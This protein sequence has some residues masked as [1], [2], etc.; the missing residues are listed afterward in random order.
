M[1][2]YLASSW[3]NAYQP[4]LVTALRREGYDV[5]DFRHPAPGNEGFQWAAIDPHWQTWTP[6]QY[7]AALEAPLA[8]LGYAQDKLALDRADVTILLLPCGRSAHLELGYAIGRG[9]HTAI[10][11]REPMEAELMYKM[12]ERICLS[13]EELFSWLAAL[14]V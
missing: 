9:Q 14:P 3:R 6:A 4:T 10:L 2:I 1:R 7:Q 13:T 11:M 5:Y 12:A 8:A